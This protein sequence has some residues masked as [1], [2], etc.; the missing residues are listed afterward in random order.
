MVCYKNIQ[1][2]SDLLFE[3]LLIGWLERIENKPSNRVGFLP[4][5]ILIF[6]KPSAKQKETKSEQKNEDCKKIKV[7]IEKY[8][9]G[10]DEGGID[11]LCLMK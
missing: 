5:L 6:M 7:E 9:T 3:R 2:G 4:N 10:S 8:G 11:I 1:K